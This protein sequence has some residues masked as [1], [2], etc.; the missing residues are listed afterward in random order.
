M[1]KRLLVIHVLMVSVAL[2]LPGDVL[3]TAMLENMRCTDMAFGADG[4]I[5]LLG[6][7]DGKIHHVSSDLDLLPLDTLSHPIGAA[8]PMP[9]FQPVCRGL[10]FDAGQTNHNVFR[11]FLLYFHEAAFIDDFVDDRSD[12]VRTDG[13][14]WN[15]IR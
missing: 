5:W 15:K 14:E 8:S 3:D 6:T 12:V 13:I 9:P 2:A 4:T 11:E 10:A 1:I 7:M